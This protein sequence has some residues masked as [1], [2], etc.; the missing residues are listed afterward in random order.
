MDFAESPW[1]YNREN[2]LPFGKRIFNDRLSLED[3]E[4]LEELCQ[5]CLDIG[6]PGRTQILDIAYSRPGYRLID[7]L[8]MN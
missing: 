8:G 3:C 6:P 2:R 4:D 7:R 1:D 5:Y